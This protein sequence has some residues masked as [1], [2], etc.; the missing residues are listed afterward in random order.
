LHRSL[1]LG[2][3]RWLIPLLI[4]SNNGELQPT[5]N[6]TL[7]LFCPM[8]RKKRQDFYDREK[9]FCCIFEHHSENSKTPR[10]AG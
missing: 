10:V 4:G 3:E 7:E 5:N 9:D 1:S 8:E 2:C 6:V